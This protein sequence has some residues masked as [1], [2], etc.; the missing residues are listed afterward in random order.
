MTIFFPLATSTHKLEA[1]VLV[2]NLEFA[3]LSFGLFKF[4]GWGLI[5]RVYNL[6]F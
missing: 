4:E 1:H 5:L 6:G 2:V 3:G